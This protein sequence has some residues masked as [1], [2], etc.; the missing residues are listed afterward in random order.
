MID[1]ISSGYLILFFEKE[2]VAGEKVE[3]RERILKQTT[4]VPLQWLFK[5]KLNKI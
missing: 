1:T 4:D 5:F 2:R 3:G